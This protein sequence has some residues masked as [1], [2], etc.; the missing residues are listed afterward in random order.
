MSS[1]LS[2]DLPAEWRAALSSQHVRCSAECLLREKSTLNDFFFHLPSESAC[3]VDRRKPR[4]E[5]R[6]VGYG[7]EMQEKNLTMTLEGL[8]RYLMKIQAQLEML[9]VS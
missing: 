5:R 8:C 6:E 2:T 4:V 9:N 7:E 3:T 1:S